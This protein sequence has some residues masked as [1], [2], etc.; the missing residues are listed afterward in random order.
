MVAP[1]P[2]FCRAAFASCG[3]LVAGEDDISAWY[4][5]PPRCQY[6]GA[7]LGLV[8]SSLNSFSSESISG[9]DLGLEMSIAPGITRPWTLRSCRAG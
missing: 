2:Y 3:Y 8:N 1:D 7:P 6:A 4:S 9:A 5:S